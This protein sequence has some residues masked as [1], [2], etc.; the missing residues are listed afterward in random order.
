[1]KY[2]LTIIVL[3]IFVSAC[4][5]WLDT[6]LPKVNT[7]PVVSTSTISVTKTEKE[8]DRKVNYQVYRNDEWGIMFNYPNDWIVRQ[9]AFGSTVSL[10][11]FSIEPTFEKKLP[12]PVLVNITPKQWIVNA[13]KKMEDRGVVVQDSNVAGFKAFKIE[14]QDMGIASVSY[15]VLI[16]DKY[17]IDF[18]AKKEYEDTL[19]Q[20]LSSLVITPINVNLTTE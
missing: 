4:Y 7:E 19:N 18:S 16:N 17:W 10:F 20:I 8:E 12:D 1:M 13:L 15:L 3:L 6:G 2:L 11:N 9:P 14:D 5:W